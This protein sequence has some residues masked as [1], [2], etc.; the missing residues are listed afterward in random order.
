[1]SLA[2]LVD[3][4]FNAPTS[5]YQNEWDMFPNS[6][7][8]A[9]ALRRS[10]FD[11]RP[12]A[13]AGDTIEKQTYVNKDGFQVTLDVQHFAPNEITVKT[14]DNTVIIEA[15]HEERQDEHGYVSRQFA[16][17]Y[18]LP[19]G[20]NAKDVVS[21]ISSDGILLVKAPKPAQASEGNV[22][23]VQVQ[24]TGPARLNVNTKMSN[25]AD[26]AR[27]Q[28]GKNWFRWK[29]RILKFVFEWICWTCHHEKKKYNHCKFIVNSI[30]LLPRS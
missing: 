10:H 11:L 16:R 8:F 26:K 27:N 14:V 24:Q 19:E 25:D 23:H 7:M 28:N 1:M 4:Y 12:Y 2:T 15:K 6:W 30:S 21:S 13:N 17:R 22:R 9:P 18:R 20:Y 29:S 3:T 5:R